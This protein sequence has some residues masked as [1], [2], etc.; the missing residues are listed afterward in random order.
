MG[1]K[2]IYQSNGLLEE[3]VEESVEES[4]ISRRFN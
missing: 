2:T 3:L 1:L 4:K